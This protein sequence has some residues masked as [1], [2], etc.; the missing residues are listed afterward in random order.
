MLSIKIDNG[1]R[2]VFTSKRILGVVGELGQE[3]IILTFKDEFLDGYGFLEISNGVNV[4]MEPL[5]KLNNL[6]SLIVKEEVLSNATELSLQF[7][8]SSEP[9]GDGSPIFKSEIFKVKVFPTIIDSPIVNPNKIPSLLDRSIEEITYEDLYGVTDIGKFSFYG[10]TELKGV[11][12]P[13]SINYIANGAFGGCTGLESV[14]CRSIA[15]WCDIT[16]GDADSNPL[17]YANNLY[18]NN[19]LV[20]SL[21]IPDTVRQIKDYAFCGA[22]CLTSVTIPESVTSIG[23]YAFQNCNNLVSIYYTGTQEDWNAIEKETGWDSGTGSYT[24]YFSL[25]DFSFTLKGDDTYEISSYDGANEILYLPET[26]NGKT[27]TSI[28]SLAFENCQGLKNVIIPNNIVSIGDSAFR[29]CSSLEQMT[30]PFVGAEANKTSLDT[31]QYPFGYIFGETEYDNSVSAT[32]LYIGQFAYEIVESIYYLPASL[33]TVFVN[34]GNILLGAFS[35]CNLITNIYIPEG[36]IEIGRYAFYRSGLLRFTLPNSVAT[37]GARAFEYCASLEEISLNNLITSIDGYTFRGCTNL[38]S[39]N[40]PDSVTSIETSAF[41]GSGLESVYIPQNVRYIGSGVFSYCKNLS[42]ISV[43]EENTS[44]FSSGN[45]IIK[46]DS[47]RLIVGCKTSIIPTDGSVTSIGESAFN[48]CTGLTEVSIPYSVTWIEKYAFSDCSGLTSITIPN[49]V[50]WIGDGAFSYCT[51]LT[52]VTIPNS[53]TGIGRNA[54][55]WCESLTSITIPDS[56]TSIGEITFL[57]CSG[58][59]SVTIGNSVTSISNFAFADCSSLTNVTI[60]AVNPPY[61][62]NMAFLNTNNCPIFVPAQSVTIYQNSWSSLA[63]RIQAIPS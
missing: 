26:Y 4:W 18:I 51:G 39:I 7:R 34:G 25:S 63:D 30:I 16:F 31:Y 41:A 49:S 59:T 53:V 15:S 40:I 14:S 45:C 8:V 36:I 2:K 9:N 56:V 44:Y 32:Q 28:A 12:I 33:R 27:V 24:V 29:G 43:S 55:S 61:L 17:Q 23:N 6:Y 47:Y 3:I 11:S 5:K 10:C 62:G 50:L 42:S 1:T 60:K 35:N 48:G 37:L 57:G 52:E 19:Q 21:V 54:F 38:S 46:R 20:V 22:S 13:S 58:L